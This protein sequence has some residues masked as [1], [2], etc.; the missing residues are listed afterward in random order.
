VNSVLW[1]DS[2]RGGREMKKWQEKTKLPSIVLGGLTP[3]SRIGPIEQG[4][5]GKS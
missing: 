5:E 1:T 3:R 4:E 2:K